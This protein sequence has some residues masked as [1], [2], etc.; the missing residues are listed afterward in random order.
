MQA[1]F[2]KMVVYVRDGRVVE[3]REVIDVKSKLDTLL[4]GFNLP[5]STTVNDV[6]TAINAVR[7]GQGD[8]PIRVRTM[9]VQFQDLGS[10]L[11]VDLPT[12]AVQGSLNVLRN[13]GTQPV[14]T[15][16]S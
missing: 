7:Q 12:D 11:R 10:P 15:P 6:V 13:R 4:R 9:H 3:V 2:R 5:A 8:E 16:A 14:A 1:D